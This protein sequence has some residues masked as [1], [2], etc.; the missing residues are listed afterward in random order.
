MVH[1]HNRDTEATSDYL[2]TFDSYAIM[3][4]VAECDFNI[5]D[6]HLRG[7]AA[8]RLIAAANPPQGVGEADMLSA[9]G[10][11]LAKTAVKHNII[12]LMGFTT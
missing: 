7:E 10:C 4:R 12:L 1:T 2:W 6:S 8:K 11:F 5:T 3:Q 9:N